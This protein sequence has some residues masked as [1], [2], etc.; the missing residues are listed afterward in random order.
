MSTLS[1]IWTTGQYARGSKKNIESLAKYPT[2]NYTALGCNF[3]CR[4][5]ADR[6]VLILK[7][8]QKLK[9]PFFSLITTLLTGSGV[10]IQRVCTLFPQTTKISDQT[11]SVN[12][13]V[14]KDPLT[15]CLIPNSTLSIEAYTFTSLPFA[16]EG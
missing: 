10:H 2:I 7:K 13:Q 11:P 6:F 14:A 16:S 3:N 1:T 12:T 9:M 5:L 8:L 4:I 15:S